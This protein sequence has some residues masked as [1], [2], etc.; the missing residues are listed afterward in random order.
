MSYLM[1]DGANEVRSLLVGRKH[2][3]RIHPPAILCC[4]VTYG[5]ISSHTL[6]YAYF[7]E[8]VITCRKPS[9]VL[10]NIILVNLRKLFPMLKLILDKFFVIHVT[11]GVTGGSHRKGAGCSIL[12]IFSINIYCPCIFVFCPV[13]NHI[14]PI[15]HTGYSCLLELL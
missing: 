12:L 2:R 7:A 15:G 14:R 13:A 6:A 11:R 8:P 5:A 10:I 3:I 9:A 4:T 1:T